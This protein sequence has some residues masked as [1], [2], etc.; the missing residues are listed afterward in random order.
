[1][2]LGQQY[3]RRESVRQEKEGFVRAVV[4]S[5]RT[6]YEPLWNRGSRQKLGIVTLESQY[7]EPKL[8][9]NFIQ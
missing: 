5:E 3:I 4:G 6:S 2:V 8:N 7:Q 1:M 9:G